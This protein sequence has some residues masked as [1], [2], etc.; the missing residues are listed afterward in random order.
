MSVTINIPSIDSL[1]PEYNKLKAIQALYSNI[2]KLSNSADGQ[3]LA[4]EF[5]DV[6]TIYDESEDK[7]I[8]N[9]EIG[10]YYKFSN[11]ANDNPAEV[12]INLPTSRQFDK[13]IGMINIMFKVPSAGIVV[14]INSESSNINYPSDINLGKAAQTCELNIFYC[15][16]SYYVNLINYDNVAQQLSLTTSD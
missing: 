3:V 14:N 15:Y 6:S 5:I 9:C 8:L 12:V 1:R 2:C 4:D 11:F 13:E 10:K 7:Y 16:D